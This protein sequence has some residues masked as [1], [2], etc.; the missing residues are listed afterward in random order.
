MIT[1]PKDWKV[2]YNQMRDRCRDLI[3]FRIWG[4]IDINQ[5]DLWR[6]NFRTDEEKY[7]SACVMDAIIFRSNEQTFSLINQLLFRDLNNH[8][9][10]QGLEEFQNFPGNLIDVYHDPKVRL[11]PVIKFDDPVT[12]SSNEVLRFMK[13]HF[14]ISESWII[15]PWNIKEY[16]DRG[17]QVIIFIDDFLGTGKQFEDIC[18]Y[19]QLDSTIRTSNNI[20]YAPLVAHERGLGDLKSQYTNLSLVC[21]EKL[22]YKNHSFFRNYFSSEVEVAKE[23]YLNMLKERDIILQSDREFGFGNLELTFSFEH[24]SPDNSLHIL[25]LRSPKWN[26]LFNR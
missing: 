6:K 22:N 24:A 12:K 16:I 11:V 8:F 3:E 13:R 14:Q 25:H 26:P 1:L 10:I 7:F 5:F 2:Y 17:I 15:N 21:T 18:I 9:R 23:F 4:G 20:L 19:N